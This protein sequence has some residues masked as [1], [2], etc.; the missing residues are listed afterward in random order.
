DAVASLA[1]EGGLSSVLWAGPESLQGARRTGLV[2]GTVRS[3]PVSLK[4][5]IGAD[6]LSYLIDLGLPQQGLS[7]FDRD[8]EIKREVVWGGPLMRASTLA[9]RRKRGLVE[10]RDEG[11]WEELPFQLAPHQSMLLD[12][13]ELRALRDELAAWRFYDTLRTDAGA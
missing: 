12:L 6:A 8:P 5:G 7:A 11:P 9:A 10:V 4:L 13:P 2:Q 3:G 1:R